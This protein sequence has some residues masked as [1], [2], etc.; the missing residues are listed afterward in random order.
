MTPKETEAQELQEALD[1]LV[2]TAHAADLEDRET[3]DKAEAMIRPIVEHH[4]FEWLGI[5]DGGY[6]CLG[7]RNQ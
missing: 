4:I 6:C 5:G 7:D 1:L 2:T 3:L